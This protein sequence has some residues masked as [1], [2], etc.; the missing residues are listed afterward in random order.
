MADPARAPHVV[1]I[2][3]FDQKIHCYGFGGAQL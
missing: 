1:S 2:D 3:V